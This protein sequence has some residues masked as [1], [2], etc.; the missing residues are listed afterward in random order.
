MLTQS[1]ESMH[2]K[3]ALSV[4]VPKLQS[5]LFWEMKKT[6]Q[7]LNS[8]WLRCIQI[9]FEDHNEAMWK[10]SIHESVYKKV[11]QSNNPFYSYVLGCQAFEQEWG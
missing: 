3:L 7:A 11:K 8:I 10:R 9:R 1:I 2:L 6:R 5:C 4:P